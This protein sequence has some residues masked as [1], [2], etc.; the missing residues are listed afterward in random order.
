MNDSLAP[1]TMAS[2]YC[3]YWGLRR[4]VGGAR[5]RLR[6][7]VLGGLGDALRLRGA[8]MILVTDAA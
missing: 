2:E 4:E 1:D 3:W 8:P 6:E 7:R 5:E